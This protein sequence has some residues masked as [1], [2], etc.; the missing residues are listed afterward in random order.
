MTLN[1]WLQI[2]VFSAAVLAVAKPLGT[3]LVRIYD[4]TVG[5][6]RPAERLLHRLCGRDDPEQRDE[7]PNLEIRPFPLPPLPVE[8]AYQLVDP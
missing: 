8:A 6:L 7:M 4:G 5:W 2:L 3:Y 1:G